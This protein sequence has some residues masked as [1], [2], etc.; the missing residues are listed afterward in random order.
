MSNCPWP[1]DGVL[2]EAAGVLGEFTAV[3][4]VETD[5]DRDVEAYIGGGE[6]SP[7]P[8]AFEVAE[9]EGIK[10]GGDEE[11]LDVEGKGA[12]AD[13]ESRLLSWLE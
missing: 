9:L 12:E 1:F 2:K 6:A 5:G 10:R 11:T 8:I 4:E 3:A 7:G 13:L